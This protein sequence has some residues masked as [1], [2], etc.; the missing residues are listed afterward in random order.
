MNTDEMVM[1]FVENSRFIINAENF[2]E[3]E[4][5]R[6]K[7]IYADCLSLI[8]KEYPDHSIPSLIICNS[9]NKY[10]TILPVK[11]KQNEYKYYLLYDRHL[12]EINRLFNA[13]FLDENDSGHDI[14]K[15]SYN[16]FAEDSALKNDSVLLTYFGL[17][18]VALG[19]FEVECEAQNNLEFIMDVQERYIIGHE[20]GHWIYKISNCTNDLDFLNLKYD[21]TWIDLL[22]NIELLLSELYAEYER[23]F[24][25]KDYINLINEQKNLLN[26]NSG[27]WEECFADAIAYAMIFSHMQ[28]D[29]LGAEDKLLLA[30]QA[31]FLVMTNLQLMA[32]HNMTVSEDSFE[33]STSIRL[34]FF[35]NYIGTYFNNNESIFDEMLEK[36]VIRYENRI[37]NII[38]EC[39]SA[40][41]KRANFIYDGLI[42]PSGLLDMSKII[43]LNDKYQNSDLLTIDNK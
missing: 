13:I 33:A 28:S 34:G 39:F 37:T 14:W 16:L 19:P 3:A 42:D 30:V 26:K 38:L 25:S 6:I 18:K 32:M 43:G 20:L 1:E 24:K 17:N 35:R 12:T 41:D 9:Y 11:T 29:Y 15:L 36:T 27:I 23:K 21:G 7:A 4:H 22:D 31:L 40:L 5:D 2:P 8:V 10:S